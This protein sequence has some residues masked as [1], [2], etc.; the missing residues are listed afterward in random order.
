MPT[1]ALGATAAVVPSSS[2]I[3][4]SP[5]SGGGRLPRRWRKHVASLGLLGT[6]LGSAAPCHA[7]LVV[8]HS[9]PASSGPGNAYVLS[10]VEPESRTVHKLGPWGDTIAN[11][12][13][14]F[15]NPGGN[16]DLRA[17][18][19]D[20]PGVISLSR[21]TM[22]LTRDGRYRCEYPIIWSMSNAQLQADDELH[23]DC[24]A[25]GKCHMNIRPAAR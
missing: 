6:L 10:W 7:F 11:D 18:W 8:V 20:Q 19:P 2:I 23:V 25:D 5:A 1:Q 3:A 16:W 4:A 9:E 17:I 12:R 21:V 13:G 14:F 22:G 15:C 24:A